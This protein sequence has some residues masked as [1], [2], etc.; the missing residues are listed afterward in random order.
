MKRSIVLS[1][2]L[3]GALQLFAQPGDPGGDPD[4]PI[5]GIEILLGIGGAWGARKLIKNKKIN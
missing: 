1:L 3:F 2:F 4:L 5:T